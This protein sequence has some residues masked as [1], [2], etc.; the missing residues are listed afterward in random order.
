MPG[1]LDGPLKVTGG[2][3]Y[4]VDHAFPDML[5]GYVVTS[6]IAH[7]EIEAI[8]VTAAKRAPGV[9]AIYSP[10]DPLVLRTAISPMFGETPVPMQDAEV[11]YHGQ[12]IAFVV[13]ESSNR[14]GTRR[15]SSGCPTARCPP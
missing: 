15:R 2:A 8:D 7:G 4:D 13:A 3:K 5:H 11:I 6:T 14:P 1:R 10:F 9:V 12:P